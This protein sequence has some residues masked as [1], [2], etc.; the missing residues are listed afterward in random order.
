VSTTRVLVVRDD[1]TVWSLTLVVG[2]L[3]S[4]VGAPTNVVDD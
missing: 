1:A 2:A 3:T 4:V